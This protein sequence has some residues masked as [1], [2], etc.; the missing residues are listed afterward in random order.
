[1]CLVIKKV[2]F[3]SSVVLLR[4]IFIIA[5]GKGFNACAQDGVLAKKVPGATPNNFSDVFRG[6]NV[7]SGRWRSVNFNLATKEVS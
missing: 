5:I 2:P 3:R 7:E 6:G 1:M 4:P